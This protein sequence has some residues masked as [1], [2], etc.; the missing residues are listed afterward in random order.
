MNHWMY[1]RFWWE[2]KAV[3]NRSDAFSYLERSKE[4]LGQLLRCAAADGGLTVGLEAEEH[5]ISDLKGKITP[6]SICLSFHTFSC[7]MEV[8]FESVKDFLSLL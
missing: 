6:F 1:T 7:F 4:M 5:L 3:C 2:V 8:C